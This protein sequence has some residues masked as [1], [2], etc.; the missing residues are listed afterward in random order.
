MIIYGVYQLV[1]REAKQK[2]ENAPP[3]TVKTEDKAP[4]I[5]PVSTG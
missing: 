3:S 4:K 2:L 5:P 1:N